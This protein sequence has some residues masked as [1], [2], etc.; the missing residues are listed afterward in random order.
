M[1]AFDRLFRLNFDGTG[2][3]WQTFGAF[4]LRQ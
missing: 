3:G 4:H 1:A 2:L